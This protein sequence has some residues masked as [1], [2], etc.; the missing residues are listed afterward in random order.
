MS[1]NLGLNA[2]GMNRLNDALAGDHSV[3]IGVSLLDL[4]E[5]FL[6]SMSTLLYDG[7]VTISGKADITRSAS[8]TLFDPDRVLSLDGVNPSGAAVYYDKMISIVYYVNAYGWAQPIGIPIFRGPITSMKRSGYFISLEAFGKE[9]L[10]KNAIWNAF[11]LPKGSY[12]SGAIRELLYEGAGERKLD[13]LF[14]GPKIASTI[15]LT[16]ESIPWDVAKKLASG[17][18]YQLFYNGRGVAT[19]RIPPTA[20]S[21]TFR[22]GTGG[23][24]LQAPDVTYDMANVR[25]IVWVKG[26]K[27]KG[28]KVA[29]SQWATLPSSHPLN[30]NRMGRNG[31][32]RFLLETIEDTTITKSSEGKETAQSRLNSLALQS[33]ETQASVLPI[34]YLEELDIATMNMQGQYAF[35]FRTNDM[36]I[37]LIPNQGGSIGTRRNAQVKRKK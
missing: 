5:N 32:P 3:S 36:V 24:I 12:K 26:G 30:H 27:A 4:E 34:P 16:R 9:I 14:A 6:T 18:G 31:T 22:N 19:M 17:M 37:P 1:L 8:L 29:V 10:A 23:T 11:G 2:A 35:S 13:L 21:F 7:Q 15:S 33:I 25:N 28:A 20:S